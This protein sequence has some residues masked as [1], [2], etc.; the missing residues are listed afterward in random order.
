MRGIE[1][2]EALR[3]GHELTAFQSQSRAFEYGNA[4]SAARL[5]AD[6]ATRHRTLV[7]NPARLYGF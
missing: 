7:R 6:A 2:R 1:S 4:R 3:A 5:G